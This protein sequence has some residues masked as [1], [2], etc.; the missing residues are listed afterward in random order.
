MDE[1]G[2]KKRQIDG[3]Y[4]ERAKKDSNTASLAQSISSFSNDALSGEKYISELLQN[5]D[6]AKSP[7]VS[8]IVTSNGY[9][10]LMHEG[11]AFTD[12]DVD[13]ICD[14][15]S[16]KRAKVNDTEQI[17]NKGVGFKAVFT[18]AETVYIFSDGYHFRFDERHTAW[19]GCVE[20]YPWQIIPI[21]TNPDELADLKS[22]LDLGKTCFVFKLRAE[23]RAEVATHLTKLTSRHLLFLRHVKQMKIALPAQE[24][25]TV[26][27]ATPSLIANNITKTPC[28]KFEWLVYQCRVTL[29][30]QLKEKLIAAQNIPEKYK[31]INSMPLQ[32]AIF[33]EGNKLHSITDG[34]KVF[35]YLPTDLDLGMNVLVNAEFL[36]DPSRMH[37]REGVAA[38]AWNKWMLTCLWEE[39]IKFLSLL[40]IHTHY[41]H[42]VFSVL[43]NPEKINW[44]N[45]ERFKTDCV[46]VFKAT[47][48]KTPLVSN[49]SNGDVLTIDTIKLDWTK[50]IQ[51]FGAQAEKN[52]CIHPGMQ[53]PELIRDLGG[54]VF[55]IDDILKAVKALGFAKTICSP[56]LNRKFLECLQ[57][58]EERM[59]QEGLTTKIKDLLKTTA[60][61]LSA[62]NGLKKSFEIFFPEDTLRYVIGSG[63]FLDLLH[64]NIYASKSLCDWLARMG[65]NAIKLPEIIK[66]ANKAPEHS[67]HFVIHLVQSGVWKKFD[68][69]RQDAFKSLRLKTRS[70]NL[71][72]EKN[73]QQSSACYLPG[74]CGPRHVL[75]TFTSQCEIMLSE[76][77]LTADINPVDLK[78]FCLF[79]GV[80]EEINLKN[81]AQF[82]PSINQFASPEQCIAFTQWVFSAFFLNQNTDMQEKTLIALRELLVLSITGQR[83]DKKLCYLSDSYE[84]EI[85]LQQYAPNMNFVVT[86]YMGIDRTNKH[87]W[88]TFF[89]RLGVH[90][91]LVVKP[92]KNL[93]RGKS[94]ETIEGANQYFLHLEKTIP[95]LYPYPTS[96]YLYQHYVTFYLEIPCAE[97]LYSS[98]V[99]WQLLIKHWGTFA[100]YLREGVIY[101][102]A[103]SEKL[104]PSN[105]HVLV[106]KAIQA[107]YGDDKQAKDF[108]PP[109]VQKALRRYA[110]NYVFAEIADALTLEQAEQLRFK[111][112]LPIIDC[113][114]KLREISAYNKPQEDFSIIIFLYQQILYY[115]KEG[116]QDFSAFVDIPLLTLAGSF[117]PISELYYLQNDFMHL[118]NPNARIIKKPESFSHQDFEQLCCAFSIQSIKSVDI[119]VVPYK[120]IDSSLYLTL[121]EKWFYVLNIILDKKDL[122]ERQARSHEIAKYLK[123]LS[124]QFGLLKIYA[125]EGFQC[126]YDTVIKEPTDLWMNEEKK[127]IYHTEPLTDVEYEDKR[128]IYHFLHVYFQLNNDIEEEVFLSLM[129]AT[130]ARLSKKYSQVPLH[131]ISLET[132]NPADDIPQQM[133]S[134]LSFLLDGARATDIE[135]SMTKGVLPELVDSS[136]ETMLPQIATSAPT[137]PASGFTTFFPSGHQQRDKHPYSSPPTVQ[138]ETAE[139]TRLPPNRLSFLGEN[140]EIRIVIGKK[141]EHFVYCYLFKKHQE[142]Y[143]IEKVK[144]TAD[145]YIIQTEHYTKVVRWLNKNKESGQPYDFEIIIR[146]GDKQKVR[147]LEVKATRSHE[148]TIEINY[149]LHEWKQLESADENNQ[150]KL[151]VVR[152]IN[153]EMDSFENM[154]IIKQGEL[155]LLKPKEYLRVAV[156]FSS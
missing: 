30:S 98:P 121:Q 144:E 97:L 92:H 116:H 64:A 95:E 36:L 120:I 9:L 137:F 65:I 81:L 55:W 50:F 41:A 119:Q 90:Q 35:C 76:E 60:L 125:A 51:H 12:E 26:S 79:V 61:I 141:G 123:R 131:W 13:A 146:K 73:F 19:Q 57:T 103:R 72:A 44:G 3:I 110:G 104:V 40:A 156:T 4:Q 107:R 21:W 108:Y 49:L 2:E 147:R 37:L 48:K 34:Q 70:T 46:A 69:P 43:T 86:D 39:L 31:H 154:K 75:E 139:P 71:E 135:F 155:L 38:D 10:I 1:T 153:L 68:A 126:C 124:E 47:M 105:I 142:K 89:V 7:S 114:A 54:Y 59:K 96:F 149:S 8:W 112:R 45:L 133:P 78:E 63:E 15:A 100:Q 20:A 80:A 145:G 85:P 101:H 99:F 25:K 122:T 67:V 33:A 14:H 6:D 16:R 148:N 5:A 27:L 74:S 140:P 117:V 127:I 58:L 28:G 94:E 130:P 22:F 113:A 109:A 136:V 152:G 42:H 29:P 91:K 134:A 66:M 115:I 62:H 23:I 132:L 118:T 11:K 93:Y 84:P 18:V 56:Q 77:Y 151:Y 82:V 102:T 17:G 129:C 138:V 32:I 87:E 52:T 88:R 128:Q 111:V 106:E 53:N 83:L 143:G 24:L 150:Y